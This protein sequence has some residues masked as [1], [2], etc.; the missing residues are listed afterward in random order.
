MRLCSLAA[1]A[2]ALV[3]VPVVAGAQAPAPV[4]ATTAATPRG[5]TVAPAAPVVAPTGTAVQSTPVVAVPVSNT[6]VDLSPIVSPLVQV[7]SAILSVIVP[8]IG[9]GVWRIVAHRWGL[10]GL[11]LEEQYRANIDTAFG[12]AMANARAKGL[13]LSKNLSID[14]K[15]QVAA[16]L[17][18]YVAAKF[19]DAVK[20]LKVEDRLKD[21]A[22]TRIGLLD[23]QRDGVV[24]PGLNATQLASDPNAPAPALP[25]EPLPPAGRPSLR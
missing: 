25:A 3:F 12:L 21:M 15:N 22:L 7:A 1:L 9:W 11:K 2:A 24:P 14:A 23:L 4:T 18:N 6:T 10:E 5:A 19:P 8:V 17:A 16:E 13:D 20:D